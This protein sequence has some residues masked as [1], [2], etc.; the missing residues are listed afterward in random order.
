MRKSQVTTIG[1]LITALTAYVGCTQRVTHG[2]F[3]EAEKAGPAAADGGADAQPG[4]APR[5]ADAGPLAV[6]PALLSIT[7]TGD[8]EKL[9]LVGTPID[10]KYT[11]NYPVQNVAKMVVTAF[12]TGDVTGVCSTA[13]GDTACDDVPFFV[14]TVRQAGGALLQVFDLYGTKVLETSVADQVIPGDPPDPEPTVLPPAV[15]AG[16]VDAGP[17][18]FA[19]NWCNANGL[20]VAQFQFCQSIDK[21]LSSHN[22]VATPFPCAR[23]SEQVDYSKAKTVPNSRDGACMDI[24]ESGFNKA[25]S[26]LSHCSASVQQTFNN[27]KSSSRWELRYAG[28]CSRSPLVVDLDGNGVELGSLDDG[29]KF[30]LLGTGERIATAWPSKGDALLAL[31]WNKNGAID[32]AAELFGDVTRGE[33]YDDGFQAL[34]ELDTN[35]DGRVDRRDPAFSQLVVWRDGNRDGESTPSEL[36]PLID[37]G[38]RSISLAAIRDDSPSSFDKFGNHIPLVSSFTR[39][40]G[41]AGMIVD[42]YFRFR[43][44]R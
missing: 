15:D 13:T 3:E 32:G 31:D 30:D 39:N 38:I 40:D 37:A 29:V 23:L 17:P 36:M 26:E 9:N 6:A 27:W 4:I 33:S 14:K 41:S 19:G 18:V 34:R 16:P 12:A 2:G 25:H 22:I 7:L 35:G 44:L 1:L 10:P 20:E 5:L 8:G 42:A 21:W 28:Y 24:I 11:A 43:P